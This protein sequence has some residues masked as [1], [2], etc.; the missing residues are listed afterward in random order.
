MLLFRTLKREL[1]NSAKNCRVLQFKLKKTEKSLGDTQS[2]LSEAESKMKSMSGGGSAMDSL[3]KV[4]WGFTNLQAVS[5]F[6]PGILSHQS[7]AWVIFSFPGAVIGEGFGG[8]EH[9]GVSAGG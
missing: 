8:K 3:N 5:Y 4:G 2:D 7:S 1:E 9:A 6:P